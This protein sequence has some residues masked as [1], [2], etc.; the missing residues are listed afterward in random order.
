MSNIITGQ[1]HDAHEPTQR[2]SSSIDNPMVV[3]EIN[4]LLNRELSDGLIMDVHAGIQKIRKCLY[5]FGLDMPVMYDFD[6]EGDEIT[7]DLKQYDNENLIIY[8]YVIYYIT[9]EGYYDFYAQVG[10]EDTINS[11]VSEDENED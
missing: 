11:L 3:G 7:F 8:L 5:R 1:A 6:Q 9:D 10:D 4:S 2:A